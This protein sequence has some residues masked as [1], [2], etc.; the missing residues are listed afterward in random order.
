MLK[1]GLLERV[2]QTFL[3]RLS[4]LCHWWN[5]GK[6]LPHLAH[7]Q[8]AVGYDVTNETEWLSSVA[9]PFFWIYYWLPSVT[10]PM[11]Q[12]DYRQLQF[13]LFG[14]IIGCHQWRLRLLGLRLSRRLRYSLWNVSLSAL[15]ICATQGCSAKMRDVGTP[16]PQ[17]TKRK[18]PP[19]SSTKVRIRQQE[20]P[21]WIF[22]FHCSA[23]VL[24]TR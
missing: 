2:H 23:T 24:Y 11:K 13:H 1:L 19:N 5:Y 6:V 12:S 21:H 18:T 16:F 8:S 17:Q 3:M 4:K 22:L 14:Y 9:I 15:H 7:Q 20:F 10:L